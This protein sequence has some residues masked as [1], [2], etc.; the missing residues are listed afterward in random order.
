MALLTVQQVSKSGV[1]NLSG[2]LSAADAAGDQV[3]SASGLLLIV[4]NGDAS[5]HTLTVAR[6]SPTKNT[7]DLGELAVSDLTLVVAAG[8]IGMI[9]IPSGYRSG[10]DFSWTY[11]AVTSVT[12]GVFA[13]NS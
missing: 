1:A 8:E 9:T 4:E 12:V 6:P 5:S 3:S 2:A 10:S 7:Q 13:L 11:D